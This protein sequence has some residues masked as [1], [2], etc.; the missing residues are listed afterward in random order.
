MSLV[1]L[2]YIYNQQERSGSFD[3]VGFLGLVG[4]QSSL[5]F[6]TVVW[7]FSVVIVFS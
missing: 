4:F 7:L 1:V 5:F 2:L 3:T 6:V